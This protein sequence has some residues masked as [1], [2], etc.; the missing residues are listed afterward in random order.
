MSSADA[1]PTTRRAKPTANP[2]FMAEDLRP[3]GY[4]VAPDRVLRG[5]LVGEQPGPEG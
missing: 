4:S 5:E 1:G 3:L 2:V